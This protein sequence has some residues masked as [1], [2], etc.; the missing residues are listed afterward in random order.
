VILASA[1]LYWLWFGLTQRGIVGDEGIS[2]LAARGV[3]EHGYP[4]LPSG[5]LYDRAYV[6]AYLLAGS[7]GLIGW[8]DLGMMLPSLVMALGSLWIT[9]RMGA[10]IFGYPRV[11]L[12]AAVL[13][14]ALQSQTF[15]ATSARMYMPLQ[16]FAVLAAYSA[17]RGFVMGERA[18]AA[19]AGLA[20]AGAILSHQQ[21]GALLVAVPFAV[22]AART[23][24][25]AGRPPLRLG[26]M[27]AGGSLLVAAVYLAILHRPAV[28]MP[29]ISAHSGVDPDHAGLNLNPA[30]WFHHALVAESTVP[31]GA[32]VLP[33]VIWLLVRAVRTPGR[34]PS[35]GLV[36]T[37]GMLAL[38]MLA[39]AAN[40]NRLHWRFWV[41]LL[42]LHV[43]LVSRGA[44]GLLEWVRGAEG[45]A[46]RPA[47]RLLGCAAW[48][49]AVFA[50]SAVAFGPTAYWT[51]IRRAYGLPSCW[52]AECSPHVEADYRELRRLVDA[53]DTVVT[54]NPMVT[55]YYL[56]HVDA[57]LRERRHD[58]RFVPFESPVDEY[59]GIPLIDHGAK[60]EALRASNG[61]V[62]VVV[63]YKARAF[64]SAAMLERVATS[65]TPSLA[66]QSMTVYVN[67]SRAG[68]DDP[69]ARPPSPAGPGRADPARWPT[70]S[71]GR[72]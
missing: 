2:L 49:L 1:A 33:W 18:F 36:F 42:P 65:F 25:G 23:M 62:W 13:L 27:V 9:A 67:A 11:G 15:Y 52:A 4:R 58:G 28:R 5:F 69:G 63:D 12:A 3:L 37:A 39:V 32:L 55:Y 71:G 19:A 8:N 30:H 14:A 40:V 44:A 38:G 60:L 6:P 51:Q 17:W 54:S 70:R 72:R 10:E 22:L 46:A 26:V 31:L 35:Q 56:R 45:A 66:G 20:V 34:G 7:I 16:G 21:G 47:R 29:M 43:L 53:A 64:F 61:R 68:A 59:F 57:F 24:Q 50:V 48:M 41:M